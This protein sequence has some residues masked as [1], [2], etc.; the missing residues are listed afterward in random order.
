MARTVDSQSTNQSSTLCAITRYGLV[1]QWSECSVVSREVAGS[2][3]ARV[4]ICPISPIG[5]GTSLR[6]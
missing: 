5:R 4:A 6:N 1:V 2:N 3:P